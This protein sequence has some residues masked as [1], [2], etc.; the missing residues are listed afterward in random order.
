[1]S[2]QDR[3]R[4]NLRDA[5]PE[6]LDPPDP[7]LLERIL[8]G[9][10]DRGDL[11]PRRRR[12]R[13]WRGAR[14]IWPPALAAAVLLAVVGASTLWPRVNGPE[15]GRVEFLA[16]TG[17]GAVTFVSSQA[18]P[19]AEYRGMKD[20]VLPGFGGMVDFNSQPSA[21]EDVARI[22]YE[23][24]AGQPGVDLVALTHSEMVTLQADGALEDLTPLVQRLQKDRRF[25]PAALEQ[26]RF[27]TDRQYS[28][29]WLQATYMMV[30]NRQA[31]RYLPPGAEVDRL[32][33][34]QLI[35]WGQSLQ[36]AT[37]QRLIG[38]P[39]DLNGTRGGLVYRFLQGYAYPSFTGT[40]LTGFRSPDAVRMWQT[41]QRL[42]SVTNPHS[43]HYTAMQD[44]LQTGEVWIAW[45]HQARLKNALADP[46]HFIAVPAPSGP[47][48]LGYMPVT[49]GLAIPKGARNP[50]GARALIDWLTR[51]KQQ[52]TASAGLGFFPVVQHVG[53]T[54][55]A[56]AEARVAAVYAA[57][58]GAVPALPPAGLGTRVDDFTAAYQDTFRRIVVDGEDITAVL[59]DETARLQGI[60]DSAGAECW[61]PDPRSRGPCRIG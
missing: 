24:K 58:P 36:A 44:A 55:V 35:A 39:A 1:V 46:A 52:A 54:G 56:A 23:V 45:D 7:E 3:L 30:V 33:Y 8:D 12:R 43:T 6:G 60:V 28:I 26:A 38:L 41:L 61:G 42:W 48:G 9:L 15:A 32:S 57:A 17:N 22:E 34:D 37:G 25:Q 53:L 18:Q 49:I 31:L 27:G 21:A 20:G 10:P 51:P 50:D 13:P 29:P 40:T 4:R 11:A 47:R 14:R 19:A 16:T 2:S 59:N 5:L